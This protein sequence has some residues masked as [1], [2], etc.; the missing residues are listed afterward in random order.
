MTRT[1]IVS[2]VFLTF[3]QSFA[4]VQQT[5]FERAV[6][7]MNSDIEAIVDHQQELEETD[8]GREGETGKGFGSKVFDFVITKVKHGML[9]K[10]P[11]EINTCSKIWSFVAARYCKMSKYQFAVASS[12]SAA[13][14][15]GVTSVRSIIF[16]IAQ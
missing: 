8:S 13:S 7:V 6:A 2:L 1:A 11:M 5:A 12:E 4:N 3:T 9:C 10:E 15:I 14:A 16:S